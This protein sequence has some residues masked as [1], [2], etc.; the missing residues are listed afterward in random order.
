LPAK[1]GTFL[2]YVNEQ[3]KFTDQNSENLEDSNGRPYA[4]G[5]MVSMSNLLPKTL[6]LSKKKTMQS[7]LANTHKMHSTGQW[8]LQ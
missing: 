5:F 7:A 3:K 2:N 4:L 6:I 1:D 8:L